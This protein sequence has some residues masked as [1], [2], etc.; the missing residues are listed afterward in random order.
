M[1]F[2][3]MH[4]VSSIFEDFRLGTPY[5]TLKDLPPGDPLREEFLRK[6]EKDLTRL[7]LRSVVL[8]SRGGFN[9][10]R[11][12]RRA[13]GMFAPKMDATPGFLQL[14]QPKTAENRASNGR[15]AA[16]KS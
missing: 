16:P 1:I 8:R 4:D 11:T 7:R 6:R 12:D 3:G 9:V 14:F 10:L 13:V 15:K 2:A 5:T